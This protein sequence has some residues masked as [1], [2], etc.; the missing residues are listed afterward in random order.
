MTKYK[1]KF[2]GNWTE[3]KLKI[4]SKYLSAYTTILR[5]TNYYKIAYID[6]FAGT[7]YRELENQNTL[8]FIETKEILKGSA[9]IAL[10]INPTFNT[11]IFVEKDKKRIKELQKLIAEHSEDDFD[12]MIENE[13]ANE[14]LQNI[15]KK[16]WLNRRAVV[17]IDPFG[18]QLEW[19][20]IEAIAD[21]KAI[22]LWILFPHAVGVNRLLKKDGKIKEA[23]RNRLNI[24]FGTTDWYNAFYK[25]QKQKTLFGDENTIVKNATLDKIGEYYL[26]RLKTVFSKV[27]KSPYKL[28]SSTGRPFVD[29]SPVLK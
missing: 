10:E 22:D 17:F 27:A 13:D 18:M 9:K 16:N 26:N 19:T 8:E 5:K 11:Y 3:K 4:I 6:A 23:W 29:L 28:L 25:E 1:Q 15:C 12:I 24:I 7:G 14:F 21:T 2:G 20:T